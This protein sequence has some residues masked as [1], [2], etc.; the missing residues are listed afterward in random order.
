M[1]RA[2][3]GVTAAD[4][5][6][7]HEIGAAA[8]SDEWVVAGERQERLYLLGARLEDS[9]LTSEGGDPVLCRESHRSPMLPTTAL[10]RPLGRAAV[11][12][13]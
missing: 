4:A 1:S 13:Y 7:Q 9:E 11:A 5:A 6:I 3:E 10:G 8:R 2:R 12:Q